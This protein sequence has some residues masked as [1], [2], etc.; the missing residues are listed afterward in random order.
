MKKS[1]KSQLVAVLKALA[2]IQDLKKG[3]KAAEPPTSSCGSDA[4]EGGGG[5]GWSCMSP[6]ARHAG[7]GQA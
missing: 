4:G 5:E 1:L 6:M 2:W 3:S 7:H